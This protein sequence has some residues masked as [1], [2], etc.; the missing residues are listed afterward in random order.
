MLDP[1]DEPIATPVRL[2][3]RHDPAAEAAARAPLP[4]EY[5]VN[6]VPVDETMWRHAFQVLDD[7]GVD[8]VAYVVPGDPATGKPIRRH[9]VSPPGVEIVVRMTA[10][11][12]QWE[13]GETS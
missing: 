4:T 1:M 11:G 2:V 7:A 6:L 8:D 9:I 3:T 10:D 13:V 12:E 5:F